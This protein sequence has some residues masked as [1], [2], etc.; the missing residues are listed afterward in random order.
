MRPQGPHLAR[1]L[2]Q[3]RLMVAALCWSFMAAVSDE[4]ECSYNYN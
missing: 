2:Q 1:F 3:M 4:V